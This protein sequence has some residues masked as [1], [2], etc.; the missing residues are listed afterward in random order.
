MYF[1]MTNCVICVGRI[2][3]DP[4]AL[5]HLSRRVTL[6]RDEERRG[7]ENSPAIPLDLTA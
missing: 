2:L 1:G 6:Q 4:R 5:C 7:N 3:C